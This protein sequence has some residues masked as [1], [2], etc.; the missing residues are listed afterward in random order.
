MHLRWGD[1]VLHRKGLGN[2][3]IHS[4]RRLQQQHLA[5]IGREACGEAGQ[6]PNKLAPN[7][8][9][10][11]IHNDSCEAEYRS[12]IAVEECI[13]VG[14]N[15]EANRGKGVVVVPRKVGEAKEQVAQQITLHGDKRTIKRIQEAY[16]WC[17]T[18]AANLECAHQYGQS[19]WLAGLRN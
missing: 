4:F 13:K 1:L 7:L 12:I 2:G 11:A 15:V 19:I 5:P 8:A 18:T 9:G 3:N 6:C 10:I 14:I 17:F 16:D